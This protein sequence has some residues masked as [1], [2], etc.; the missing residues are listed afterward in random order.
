M[1]NRHLLSFFGLVALATA[2]PLSTHSIPSTSNSNQVSLAPLVESANPILN[3]Y[4]VVLKDD[5]SPAV[6]DAH[7]NFV[8]NTHAQAQATDDVLEDIDHGLKHVYDSHIKGYAGTFSQST[9]DKIRARPEVNYVEVDQ[10][11]HT[12]NTTIQKSAPWV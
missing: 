6:L 7:T 9:V 12:L 4:I 5:V 1:Y 11:V 8:Q 2:S 3:S 10:V